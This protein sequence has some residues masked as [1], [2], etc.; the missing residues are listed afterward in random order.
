MDR[1]GRA[2]SY[3]EGAPRR[4]RWMRARSRWSCRPLDISDPLRVRSIASASASS[5]SVLR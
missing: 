1:S 2:G 4:G 5:S 3:L